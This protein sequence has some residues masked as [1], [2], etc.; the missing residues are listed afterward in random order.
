MI[1]Q[2]SS[3]IWTDQRRTGYARVDKAYCSGTG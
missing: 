2:F 1:A 3:T